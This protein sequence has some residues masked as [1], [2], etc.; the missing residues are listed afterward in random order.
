MFKCIDEFS[1]SVKI[2]NRAIH[3]SLYRINCENLSKGLVV[4]FGGGRGLLAPHVD[5]RFEYVVIDIDPE[6]SQGT[7]HCHIVGD[8]CATPF[9]SGSVD[10]GISITSMQ[11]Y[12]HERFFGECR[13]VLSKGAILAL[14]ENGLCNPF[15]ILSR[16]CQRFIG[17]FSRRTWKY[18][19]SI[20]K[21]YNPN[22]VPD[23]FE[24]VYRDAD[25]LFSPFAFMLSVL[26]I[27]TS[28]KFIKFLHRID[29]I[30]LSKFPYLERFVFLNVIHL[31]RI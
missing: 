4:D 3:K 18:R 23:G 20:I 24:I 1:Y 19:N 9:R 21:Y 31:R 13:R 12:E 14:H 26:K 17:I 2:W 7:Q 16:I 30:C 27:P 11:Y 29:D 15:I 25:G 22:H 8:V 10:I 6:K 5:K 28:Q